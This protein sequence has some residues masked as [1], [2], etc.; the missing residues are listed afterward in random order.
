MRL[1]AHEKNNNTIYI[2]EMNFDMIK[3]I[4][5]EFAKRMLDTGFRNG[6]YSPVGLFYIYE[7][8]LY[9]GFDNSTGECWVEEFKSLGDCIRWLKGEEL[10]EF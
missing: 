9:I 1:K 6:R 10:A 7:N 5:N 4:N 8:G 2:K 3:K